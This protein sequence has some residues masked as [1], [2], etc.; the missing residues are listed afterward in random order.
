M[1]TS[2]EHRQ[3]AE[4]AS[5]HTIPGRRGKTKKCYSP[6]KALGPQ[7]KDT[8]IC[9][10]VHRIPRALGIL[11]S[12]PDSEPLYQNV[13]MQDLTLKPRNQHQ[14]QQLPPTGKNLKGRSRFSGYDRVRVVYFSCPELVYFYLPVDKCWQ[15]A[16]RSMNVGQPGSG[17]YNILRIY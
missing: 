15:S 8:S 1:K 12:R 16:A 7:R 14:R 11:E 5:Q 6:R 3:K 13:I 17:H 4:R 10:D 9:R 2:C